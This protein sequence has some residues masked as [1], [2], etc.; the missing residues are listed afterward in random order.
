MTDKIIEIDDDG[1]EEKVLNS[2]KPVMVDFWAPWC[3]PC[4]AIA[5]TVEALEKTYGDQ[6]T[7]AKINVDENP[8]SPSKYGVQAIPTL[9]FFK[10]GEIADQITGMVAKEKLEQTIKKVL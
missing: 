3:G 4:K 5:P 7:F 10:N 1:F 8:L 2:E 6:M 9:I